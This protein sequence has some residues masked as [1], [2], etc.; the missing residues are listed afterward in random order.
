[1]HA[2]DSSGGAGC[3]RARTDGNK[4]NMGDV[5]P[6]DCISV[7]AMGKKGG[8]GSSTEILF[9]V[10]AVGE[11]LF[12]IVPNYGSWE[13]ATKLLWTDYFGIIDRAKSARQG[14][15]AQIN[16]IKAP[17]GGEDIK[18]QFAAVLSEAIQYCELMNMGAHLEYFNHFGDAQQKYN[19]ARNVDKKVQTDY[20]AFIEKYQAEKARLTSKDF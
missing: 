7:Q 2:G 13:N 20:Q 10:N 14:I 19:A 6:R 18:Q 16:M 1:M 17:Q 11:V 4:A 9:T 15:R 3:L 12:T 8:K 5:V